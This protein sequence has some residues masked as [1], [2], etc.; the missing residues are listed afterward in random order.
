[1]IRPVMN[2]AS[3]VWHTCSKDSL[4]RILRLQKRAARTIL[5][6]YARAS[7]VKLFNKLRWLPFYND[8]KIAKCLIMFKRSQ[9]IVPQYLVDSL[10]L[11]SNVHSRNTRYSKSNFVCPKFKRNL[12]EENRL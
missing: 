12:K 2:Y 5:D 8:A 6:A 7:S 4:Q 10:S 11:N 3:V 1:M 9:D